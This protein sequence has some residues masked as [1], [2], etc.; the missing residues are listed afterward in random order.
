M[1]RINAE[2]TKKFTAV[3]VKG[4]FFKPFMNLVNDM[5]EKGRGGL[6]REKM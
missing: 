2:T 6:F 3:Q 4:K 1:L 5:Y